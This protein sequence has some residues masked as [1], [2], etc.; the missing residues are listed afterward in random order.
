M[1]RGVRR[2]YVDLTNEEVELYL[3][4]LDGTVTFRQVRLALG[5]SY[6]YAVNWC[7]RAADFLFQ[8]KMLT[9]NSEDFGIVKYKPRTYQEFIDQ[10]NRL[11]VVK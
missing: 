7:R 11:Q 1:E 2:T 5:R 9:I 8:N 6:G 4:Y 3:A 10:A